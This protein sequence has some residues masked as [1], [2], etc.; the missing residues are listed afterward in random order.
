MP[1]NDSRGPEHER[2]N[3]PESLKPKAQKK[4]EALQQLPEVVGGGRQDGVDLVASGS[5]ESVTVSA[6]VGFDVPDD[7]FDGAAAFPPFPQKP[8]KAF[9]EPGQSPVLRDELAQVVGGIGSAA[10]DK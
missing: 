10:A 6:A 5:L 8:R 9:P 3:E 7:R 4:G 2:R 1:N